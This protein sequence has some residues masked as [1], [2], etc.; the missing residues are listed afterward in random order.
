MM[1]AMNGRADRWR[2]L[3]GIGLVLLVSFLLALGALG[4]THSVQ[5]RSRKPWNSIHGGDP[6]RWQDGRL[7]GGGSHSEPSLDR[8]GS[9]RQRPRS[10]RQLHA[11]RCDR[12]W[13]RD[14][15]WANRTVME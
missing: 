14:R 10:D 8:G 13:E 2:Q 11:R 1:R 12:R 3:N 7:G 5:Q 4:R 6:G 15:A 9:R